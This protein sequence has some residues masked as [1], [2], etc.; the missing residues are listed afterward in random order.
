[1][2]SS[3][4]YAKLSFIKLFFLAI[5]GFLIIAG[6][7]SDSSTSSDNAP[8]CGVS[9]T[10]NGANW[11]GTSTYTMQNSTLLTVNGISV[12]VG[13]FQVAIMD[14]KG[15]GTYNSSSLASLTYTDAKTQTIYSGG[16]G[17]VIITKDNDSAIEGTFT[18]TATPFIG[19]GSEF[20]VS[21][22]KFYCKK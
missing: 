17:K 10:L 12:G 4:L 9:F 1:M 5:A 13:A 21:D 11:C 16:S 6:C 8:A 20:T 22:G 18:F 7:S 19:S 14:Y 3:Y 15:V 2:I